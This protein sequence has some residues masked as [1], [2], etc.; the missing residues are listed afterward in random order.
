MGF[1]AVWR[2]RSRDPRHTRRGIATERR[3]DPYKIG[4]SNFSGW[5][6]RRPPRMA[7]EITLTSPV[8]VSLVSS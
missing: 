1:V 8:D 2:G 4:H 5:R 3:L 6:R 7:G